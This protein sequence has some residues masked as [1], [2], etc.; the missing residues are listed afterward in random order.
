MTLKAPYPYFG[1][2]SRAA[3]LVW[4]RFGAVR[5]Y[6]EPFFGSGAMLLARPEGWTGTE[7]VNDADGMISNFWRALKDDPAAV[8]KWADWPVNENDLHARHAWLV[9]RKDS[10][11]ARLEGDPD[12]YCPKSAGWWVWGIAC[13]IGGGFCSGKGPWHVQEVDGVRQLV[14]LGDAGRGVNRQLVHLGNAGRGVNRKLVHL[15]DGRGVWRL[16][17]HLKHAGQGVNGAAASGS[18]LDW[19]EALADRLARVRVCCGDWKRVCGPTPTVKQGLTGV[20]LDPPYADTAERDPHIYRVDSESVAHDVRRWALEHGDDPRLRI[21]LCGYEGEH[22]MPRSW[23]CVPWKALGG[24]KFKAAGRGS[25]NS[26]RERIWFSKSC[27]KP[28][29]ARPRKSADASAK[30]PA[31]RKAALCG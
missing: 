2:K 5:N 14:H 19:F 25:A 23:A 7:T 16:R 6:V 11:Q 3:A 29:T 22:T 4:P 18:L 12:F 27:L 30:S 13:W 10:L 31:M 20:F 1:G 9:E 17:V 28:A 26:H 8:A 15:G 24:Y 21:A